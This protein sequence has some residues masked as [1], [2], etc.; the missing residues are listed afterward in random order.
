MKKFNGLRVE[1]L[2][3]IFRDFAQ[4]EIGFNET[5]NLSRFI[6]ER[7]M[8]SASRQRFDSY[9]AGP[10]AQIQETHIANSRGENVEECLA[11]AI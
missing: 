3:L 11:Q 1:Y 10:R 4:V 6:D 7:R 5:A 9:S 2:G 8:T